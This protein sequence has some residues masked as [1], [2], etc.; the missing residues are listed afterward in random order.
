MKRER[1]EGRELVNAKAVAQTGGVKRNALTILRICALLL[2]LCMSWAAAETP[3]EVAQDIE[4]QVDLLEVDHRL[5]E[6]GYRDAACNGVLD[7]ITVN[8]L[9]NF[10][11]VNGLVATGIPDTATVAL[12]LS[13]RAVGESEYLQSKVTERQHAGVLAEGAYGEDVLKLQ[14]ALKAYGYFRDNCD[15]AFGAATAA[16]VCRFQ[17]ANGLNVTG[18]ADGTVFLR[19]Y[20]GEPEQWSDFLSQ[21][22][23]GVGDSGDDVRLIQICLQRKGYFQGECTGKYGGGTRQAVMRFQAE[24]GLEQS[25]SMDM[26]TAQALFFDAARLMREDAALRPGETGAEVRSMC[27]RLREL[28]YAAADTYNAQTQ[29]ALMQFQLVNGLEA[30]GMAGAE[31][32]DALYTDSAK[33]AGDFAASGAAIEPEAAALANIAG[34]AEAHL[35]ERM[36]FDSDFGFVQYVYL[37]CDLPLMDDTRIELAQMED[38]S[39]AQPGQAVT[40]EAGERRLTGIIGTDGAWIYRSGSGYVVR[41]YPDTMSVDAYYLNRMAEAAR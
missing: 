6:L 3:D 38:M 31:T 1:I 5:Y 41:R 37:K 33:R 28:G 4:A 36:E 11:Q 20:D 26:D 40:L 16:A 23:A 35:G 13:D 34:E 19:L 32:L 24:C 22:C 18:S 25:G 8:A 12:L 15:G 14:R 29:L 30:S 21:C 39:A 2:A 10:Q 27:A 9:K 17:L 7:D